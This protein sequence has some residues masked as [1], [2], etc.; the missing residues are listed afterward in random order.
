MVLTW[1]FVCVRWCVCVWCSP[2]TGRA[3]AASCTLGSKWQNVS[4]CLWAHSLQQKL[5]GT[6]SYEVLKGDKDSAYPVR[7]TPTDFCLPFFAHVAASW[8]PWAFHADS[9]DQASVVQDEVGPPARVLR[10]SV[11]APLLRL[12]P[13]LHHVQHVHRRPPGR[14]LDA[15]HSQLLISHLRYTPHA[16]PRV[17]CR[18]VS[19][20]VRL[21]LWGETKTLSLCRGE[22][23]D[24]LPRLRDAALRRRPRN[25]RERGAVGCA[26]QCAR[27]GAL[28]PRS[29]GRQGIARCLPIRHHRIRPN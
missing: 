10:R 11:R 2:T 7:A 1:H 23:R 26:R 22:Q 5:T 15:V 28:R 13:P 14:I 20:V 21:N 19:R 16:S 6:P 25:D 29:Q 3:K 24:S 27:P 8:A 9:E 17:S 4:Y 12:V 18:V